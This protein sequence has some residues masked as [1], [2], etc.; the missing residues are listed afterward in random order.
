MQRE[1]AILLT[2]RC[3]DCKAQLHELDGEGVEF[4]LR[5]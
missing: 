1:K 2:F 3:K 4:N 5:R